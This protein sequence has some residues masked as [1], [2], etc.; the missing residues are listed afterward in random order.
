MSDVERFNKM[1][2][3]DPAIRTM[4]NQT[5]RKRGVMSAQQLAEQ[6]PEVFAELVE[7]ADDLVEQAPHN[8][9]PVHLT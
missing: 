2:A 9:G 8:P 4:G 7:C 1:M 3:D 5:F 6:H